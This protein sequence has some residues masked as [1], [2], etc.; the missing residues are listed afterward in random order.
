MDAT[1]FNKMQMFAPHAGAIY[2][3]IGPDFRLLSQKSRKIV[4]DYTLTYG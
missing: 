4:T 2:A 1:S 3:G